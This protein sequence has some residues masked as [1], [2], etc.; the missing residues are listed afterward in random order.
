MEVIRKLRMGSSL[1]INYPE[2]ERENIDTS[3][4]PVSYK[5]MKKGR[6]K[7]LNFRDSPISNFPLVLNVWQFDTCHP[8]IPSWC[9]IPLNFC[10][11]VQKTHDYKLFQPLVSRFSYFVDWDFFIRM[12]LIGTALVNFPLYVLYEK[13]QEKLSRIK[14]SLRATAWIIVQAWHVIKA[15]V[16]SFRVKIAILRNQFATAL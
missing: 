3:C 12:R 10:S 13:K 7:T 4:F 6:R 5:E 1:R 11:R 2:S 8:S 16:R 15:Q 9:I 14:Y